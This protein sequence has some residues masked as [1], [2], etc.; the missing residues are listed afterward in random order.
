MGMLILDV[1][2]P[3]TH[4]QLFESGRQIEESIENLN[5]F[6]LDLGIPSL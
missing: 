2:L 3:S 1:S 6:M 5:E 4:K